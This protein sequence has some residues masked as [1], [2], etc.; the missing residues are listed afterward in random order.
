[1]PDTGQHDFE[2]AAPLPSL[3]TGETW[4]S[5]GKR[6]GG[7]MTVC[8]PCY[9]D[10]ARPLLDVLAGL[11]GAASIDLI[12]YDDGSRDSDMTASLR[13]A[14][15]GLPGQASLITATANRG[16]SHARNRLVET[17]GSDWILFLDADMRPDDGA[18]LKRYIEA[19]REAGGPA[20]IAGG[21][22]LRHV[23]PDRSTAL[24][25]AQSRR[26]ECL[27]AETR[28][29]APGRY[30]FTSNILVHRTILDT[31]GFDEGF[32]G[33]GWEDVDWG[34]RVADRYPVIHIDNTATHLG[35]DPAQVLLDKFGGSSANFARLA[36]RHPEAVRT[37]PLYRMAKRA[38]R[39]PVRSLWRSLTRAG[40]ASQILPLGL[41]L[42]C[43]KTYRAIAY[44]ED[45]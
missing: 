30:V 4:W 11:D 5:N 39:L 14:L 9:H 27:D 16:R 23:T 32:T 29:K 42:A 34:L 13:A 2:A 3:A 19:A 31:V 25:A 41:R 7:M 44:S 22:S 37:M 6:A 45:L 20:L 26:S 24:H 43:L 40:A 10:D 15:D 8:V 38:R 35:L 1:M 17:A 21:F 33:W 12:A 28:R 36:E 18:F